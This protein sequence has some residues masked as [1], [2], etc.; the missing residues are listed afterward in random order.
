LER[1]REKKEKRKGKC[2]NGLGLKS[3]IKVGV[4][5]RQVYVGLLEEEEKSLGK[6][7]RHAVNQ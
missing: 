5:N 6:N 4:Q 2:A 3:L 1:E 7:G